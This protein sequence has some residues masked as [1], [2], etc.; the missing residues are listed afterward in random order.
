MNRMSIEPLSSNHADP[1]FGEI[2]TSHTLLMTNTV[3][4]T[5]HIADMFLFTLSLIIVSYIPI[6]FTIFGT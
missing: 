6:T 1:D 4:I 2:M 5:I 3:P